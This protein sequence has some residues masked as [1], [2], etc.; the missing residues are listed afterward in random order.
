LCFIWIAQNIQRWPH[1]AGGQLICADLGSGGLRCSVPTGCTGAVKLIAGNCVRCADGRVHADRLSFSAL[2]GARPAAVVA[3]V[4]VAFF[5]CA[6]LAAAAM[7]AGFTECGSGAQTPG[8]ALVD[9]SP[10]G[11][12]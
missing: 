10:G 8:A 6:Q 4:L 7:A 3:G 12:D 9:Y 11:V 2:L 5:S 1:Y